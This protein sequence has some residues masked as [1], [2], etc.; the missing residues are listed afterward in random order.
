MPSPR[1]DAI[2][3]LFRERPELAVEILRELLGIDVP[4]GVPVR[5]E[6][7]HRS[8]GVMWCSP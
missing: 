8:P 2:N 7:K 6:L 5:L 3:R 4:V 1:H